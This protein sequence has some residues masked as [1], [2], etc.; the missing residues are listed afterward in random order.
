MC[1]IF[2]YNSTMWG[3]SQHSRLGAEHFNGAWQ[4]VFFVLKKSNAPVSSYCMCVIIVN[5]IS[6]CILC[7]K[8]DIRSVSDTRYFE[9]I[10]MWQHLNITDDVFQCLW[11]S[12]AKLKRNL[13]HDSLLLSIGWLWLSVSSRQPVLL[14]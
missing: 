13:L 12:K 5:M 6:L 1:Q 14:Q 10:L 11:C 7:C 3:W 9:N 2:S 4:I 8:C